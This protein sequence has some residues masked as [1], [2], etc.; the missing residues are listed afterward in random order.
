[1]GLG[2]VDHHRHGVAHGDLV[3]HDPLLETAR[4]GLRCRPRQ[5]A[6]CRLSLD[7]RD[8]VEPGF[9]DLRIGFQPPGGRDL[10]LFMLVEDGGH[11][12]AL[13][14]QRE[15]QVVQQAADIGA[16]GDVA[17]A[18]HGVDRGTAEVRAEHG[19][20]TGEI[21]QIEAH[22]HRVRLPGEEHDGFLAARRPLDLG[23]L[24]LFARFDQLEIAEIEQVLLQHLEHMPVAV[25]AGLDAVDGALQRGGEAVDVGEVPQARLPGIRRHRQRVLGA[26]EIR[27]QH[28][29]RSLVDVAFAVG[30]LGRHPVAEKYVDVVVLQRREGH[31]HREERS[32]RRVTELAQQLCR[33]RGGRRHVRP[34]HIGEAHRAAGGRVR[35]NRR[36]RRR[37]GRLSEYRTGRRKDQQQ[38]GQPLD[39]AACAAPESLP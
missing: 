30:F 27:T 4:P 38:D 15:V 36:I 31:G 21:A 24:A 19:I 28:L 25:V 7:G 35:Q 10:R 11:H 34:S 37:G 12:L 6:K 22:V 9:G 20:A 13:S 17:L 23:K 32:R 1:M 39:L 2:P 29:D 16:L 5:G 3:A 8:A 33:E 26:G 18:R 14:A